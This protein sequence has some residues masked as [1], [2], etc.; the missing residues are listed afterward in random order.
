MSRMKSRQSTRPIAA[1]PTLDDYDPSFE[2]IDSEESME[3]EETE[4]ELEKL[5]FGDEAGF[6]KG[7]SAYRRESHTIHHEG[8]EGDQRDDDQLDEHGEGIEGVDD[9][10][11]R[12]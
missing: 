1:S 8:I 9:A 11:V 2:G 6:Q 12:T 5:V 7:L 10:D 4:L 3:K